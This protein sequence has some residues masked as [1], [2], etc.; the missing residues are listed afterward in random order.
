MG[1]ALHEHKLTALERAQKSSYVPKGKP[2]PRKKNEQDN[3][4]SSQIP[5]TLAPTNAKEQH[6]SSEDE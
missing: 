6:S 3:P 1:Y 5:N 4:S 2:F